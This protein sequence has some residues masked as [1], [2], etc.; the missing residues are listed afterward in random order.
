M[1]V[2]APRRVNE[3][4]AAR[5]ISSVAIIDRY[6]AHLELERRV[7]PHTRD[8]Y[9]LDLA[10]LAAFA[11][12]AGTAVERLERADLERF[13][14]GLMAEG[15]SPRSVGRLVAAVRGFYR[16]ASARRPPPENPAADL[17]APRAWKALPKFLTV[18]EVDALA[19][20]ARRDDAARACATARSSSCSTPPACACRSCWR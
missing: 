18:A 3:P 9:A 14:R 11:A 4:T 10:K 16:F 5:T 12:G 6:L 15:R 2:P 7:S 1:L 19:G 8:A 17:Q 20:R 13:V